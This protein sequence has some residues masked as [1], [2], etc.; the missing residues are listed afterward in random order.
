MIKSDF[1]CLNCK[2]KNRIKIYNELTEEKITDILSREIF[3]FECSSCHEK[4]TLD[5]PVL[6]TY[7]D[8][9]IYYSQGKTEV[10]LEK[11]KQNSRI[12]VTY[13]DFK[14]KILIIY[15]DLN[16]IVIEFIKEFLL[17][18]LDKDLK[19]KVTDIRYDGKNEENLIFYL[20][21][22]NK[23]IGCEISFYNLIKE[24]STL[25]DI[26]EYIIVDKDTYIKYFKMRKI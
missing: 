26:D 10:N 15:D 3:L 5:Y 14:E 1:T 20:L 18:Q 2:K 12:C 24:K 16:D 17:N 8:Y 4:I 23:S 11:N 7:N 9:E 22:L 25:K 21:G 6:F 13:D 19:D